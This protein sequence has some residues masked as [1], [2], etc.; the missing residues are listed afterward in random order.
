[1]RRLPAIILAGGRATRMG[2]GDKGL[3]DLDGKTMLSHVID[4]VSRQCDPVALNA[5]GDPRRFA[6]FGLPV[7]HDEKP[8]FPGPL[9]GILAG[10]DWAARQQAEAVVSVAADSPFFPRDLTSRLLAARGPSGLAI[11]VSRDSSGAPADHPTFGL[12]PVSLRGALRDF[13]DAGGRRVR[14]FAA[15]LGAG[16]AVWD[17][18]EIDPFFNVNS[19]EDLQRACRFIVT[20]QDLDG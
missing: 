13:L 20:R 4:R 10:M 16:R 19:P 9:A 8:D 12:W 6:A 17:N 3:L 7:I 15:C 14:E 5:N 2:G 18:G 1:M 11:A